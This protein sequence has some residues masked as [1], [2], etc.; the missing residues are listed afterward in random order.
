MEFN[1]VIKSRASVRKYQDKN[2]S[3]QKVVEAI[4][5]ANTAPSPGNL[6]ILRYIIIEDK[7]KIAKIAQASRQDFVKDAKYVVVVCSFEEKAKIMY[8]EMS[9]NYI[10][11]HAGAAIEN[12]LLKIVELG[13][14]SCW[15]GA[16]S[17]MTIKHLLKIPDNINIQ[18]VLPVAFE[19]KANK[20]KQAKKTD[21]EN[22]IY[23]EKYNQK[24]ENLPTS[25]YA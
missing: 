9:D 21:L 8:N 15:V 14:S 23:F 16:F 17:E 3:I 25:S 7:E 12:F 22:I 1:S 4:E 13:L 5:A 2:F 10:K 18:A 20:T 19:A 24:Y 11:Q 6:A